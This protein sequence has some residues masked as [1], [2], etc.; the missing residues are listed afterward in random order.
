[1]ISFLSRD[2]A[3]DSS[4]NIDVDG[5]HLAPPLPT[6]I[7]ATVRSKQGIPVCERGFYRGRHLRTSNNC[8]SRC[9]FLPSVA[10]SN[11]KR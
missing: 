4:R 11:G 8:G 10:A 5:A 2:K 6:V 7:E 3:I 9:C 1:M